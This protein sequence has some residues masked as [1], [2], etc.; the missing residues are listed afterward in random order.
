[1]RFLNS[2]IWDRWRNPRHVGDNRAR[3]VVTV[4]PDWWLTLSSHTNEDNSGTLGTFDRG[5]VSWWQREDGSQTEAQIPAV[6]VSW[7]RDADT[8]TGTCTIKVHNQKMVDTPAGARAVGDPGHYS[9]RRGGEQLRPTDGNP[10]VPRPDRWGRFPNEWYG[11]IGAGNVYRT[12]E[13][14]GPPDKP[15]RDAVND[16]DIV[17]TG[18]WWC[19]DDGVSEDGT[20]ELRC[21]GLAGPLL[22]DQRLLSIFNGGI[23][24]GN[25][26]PLRYARYVYTVEPGAGGGP[27]ETIRYGVSYRESS[28]DIRYPGDIVWYSTSTGGSRSRGAPIHG[29]FPDQACDGRPDTYWLSDGYSTAD[30]A[31]A[32]PW[33]EFHAFNR[34]I[35]GLRFNTLDGGYQ[36]YVSVFEEGAWKG[37]NTIP[38][39]AGGDT[40]IGAD[41]PYVGVYSVPA[42]VATDINLPRTYT[43]EFV[44]LTF[45]NLNSY[46]YAPQPF[47][48]GLREIVMLRRVTQNVTVGGVPTVRSDGN[49]TD[50]SDPVKDILLWSGYWLLP[51]AGPTGRHQAVGQPRILGQIESTGFAPEDGIPGETFD[52]RPPM[53]VLA[54]LADMVSY[55]FMEGPDG[56]IHWHT[57]NLYWPGNRNEL[58]L[59]TTRIEQLHESTVLLDPQISKTVTPLRSM[60][61]ISS[62]EPSTYTTRTGIGAEDVV[63]TRFRPDFHPALRGVKKPAIWVNGTFLDESEQLRMA[64]LLSMRMWM[65]ANAAA[66]TMPG[67]PL[68]GPDDQ[69]R[70]VNATDSTDDIYYILGVQSDHNTETGVYEMQ[71]RLNFLGDWNRWAGLPTR[72][73]PA[74]RARRRYLVEDDQNEET[75]LRRLKGRMYPSDLDLADVRSIN[76]NVWPYGDPPTPGDWLDW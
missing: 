39:T 45:R 49:M 55:L 59:W 46:P 29:R 44:R 30:G 12:Y 56:E 36:V 51:P 70:L 34:Q 54:E 14:Y 69:V 27:T 38:Y 17:Q 3:L 26:Y 57:R 5:P 67:N 6:S 9:P 7:S 8:P 4:E 20:I 61:T 16:G 23:V 42:N 40:N 24:P 11:L 75:V 60:V 37:T 62:N 35:D 76:R 10:P 47:R 66:A 1:M 33:I 18:V 15:W 63:T 74:Y 43:A 48:A 25:R 53:D 68:L 13:G 73:G 2:P 31:N 65:A 32:R 50:L 72:N 19:D 21:R 52:K 22:A 28:G 41:I 71:L 64:Q 58:G